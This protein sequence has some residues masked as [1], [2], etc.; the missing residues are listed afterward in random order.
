MFLELI[1][2]ALTEDPISVLSTY[3]VVYNYLITPDPGSIF[4]T[5]LMDSCIY[6]GYTH[7]HTHTHTHTLNSKLIKILHFLTYIPFSK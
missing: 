3:L 6:L 2:L 5:D 7:T 1:V 4:L